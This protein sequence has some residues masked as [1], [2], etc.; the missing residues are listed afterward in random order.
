MLFT[1]VKFLFAPS[2]AY[3]LGYSFWETIFISI[4]GGWFGVFVFYYSGRVVF[5]W[6]A[7]ISK[8]SK[9]VFSKRNRFIVWFKNDFGLAGITLILGLGSIPIVCLLAA[10]YFRTNHKTIYLLLVSTVIWSFILTGFSV[11]LIPIL[12]G[13]LG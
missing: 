13:S 5:D 2:T 12:K 6:W 9:W 10:K 1:S 3:A 4:T 8:P 7:K 11:W